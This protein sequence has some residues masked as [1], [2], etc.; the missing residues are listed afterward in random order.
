MI[1]YIIGV[2]GGGSGTRVRLAR[3]DGAELARANGAAS[4]LAHGIEAA[5]AAIE[6]TIAQAFASAAIARPRHEQLAIGL[7]L[8]G[9]S[10]R[11]RCPLFLDRNPGYAA[12]ALETDACTTLLGAHGGRPGAI[13]ALGTGSV[14]AVLQADGQRREVGGWAFPAGDEG[15]AAWIG[16]L[17]MNHAQQTLDG[18]AAPSPLSKAVIAA[19]GGD[20]DA[21]RD[22]IAAAGQSGYATLATLVLEHGAADPAAGVIL[23]DAGLQVAQMAHALDPAGQLPL[24]L[25]GGLAAP[26]TH[27]LPHSLR[28]RLSAPTADSA[29]GA[30][31]LIRRQVN[32]AQW[33]NAPA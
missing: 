14:G 32:A 9:A 20:G 10:T 7:G 6:A 33:K 11:H 3:P 23:Y 29:A 26:L 5:W 13:V 28:E 21:L 18:R 27:Y 8:A 22:W 2:D 12:I 16:L 15:G 17:A 31:E 1:E 30:L 25:C 24:A 4:S 19:C